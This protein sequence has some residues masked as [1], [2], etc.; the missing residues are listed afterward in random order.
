MPTLTAF[1]SGVGPFLLQLG[2]QN[3]HQLAV[4]GREVARIDLNAIREAAD[5]RLVGRQHDLDEPLG[6]L[7]HQREVRLHAAAAVEQDDDGDRLDV[8]GEERELL[9]LAVVEDRKRLAREIRHE[10]PVRARHGRIH[11]HGA[12]RAA[13][14]RLLCNQRSAGDG[15]SGD[16]VSHVTH[17]TNRRREESPRVHPQRPGRQDAPPVR[18]RRPS[19]DSLLLP[20]RRHAGLHERIV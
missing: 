5:A 12:R 3:L 13:E 18:L 7:L 9:R 20:E 19:G 16:N 2:P 14:R 8:V 1:H 4:I 10:P 11:G 6:R 17:P 15:N